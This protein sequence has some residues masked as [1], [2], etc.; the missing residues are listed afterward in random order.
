MWTLALASA[1]FLFIHLM[2][3]ATSL[4]DRV[5]EKIGGTAYY[6]LF[7]LLS[8]GGLIWL[9]VAFGMALGDPMNYALWNSGPFLRVIG[10]AGNFLAFLLVVMGYTTPSATSLPALWHMPEKPVYGI[11]RITRHPVLAGIGIWALTHMIC[12]G[13]LAAWIFFGS[14]LALCGLGANTIDRKRM[15]LMGDVYASIMRRTSIVPFVAIIE[16]RIAFDAKELGVVRPLLAVSMFSVF[17]T[18]HELLFTVRAF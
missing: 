12:N 5:I 14:L 17:L 10:I 1:F 16:G 4:K 18:L 3:S 15:T 8:I 13:N 9:C 6:I 2:I 11:I 7:S